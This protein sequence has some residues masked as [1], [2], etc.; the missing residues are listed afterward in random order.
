[1]CPLETKVLSKAAAHIWRAVVV[2]Q[3][4][5]GMTER[6]TTWGGQWSLNFAAHDSCLENFYVNPSAHA[7]LQPN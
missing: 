2:S 4:L 5:T 7:A 1:M 3:C 6:V